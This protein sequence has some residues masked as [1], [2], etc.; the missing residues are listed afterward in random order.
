LVS[1]LICA[2][3]TWFPFFVFD[4][5]SD[6]EFEVGDEVLDKRLHTG[7]PKGSRS[8]ARVVQPRR[9]GDAPVINKSTGNNK[10][11]TKPDDPEQIPKGNLGDISAKHG[12]SFVS[13][14]PTASRR[15]PTMEVTSYFGLRDRSKCGMT[16]T[17]R[18]H[19]SREAGLCINMLST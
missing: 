15:G 8:N 16:T 2:F 1:F 13:V 5:F 3:V 11:P 18:R 19:T 14:I 4:V 7:R 12:W 6:D 10:R 17:M 9:T